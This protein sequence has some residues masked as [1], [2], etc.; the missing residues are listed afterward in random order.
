[1]L[2]LLTCHA[3]ARGT[4]VA[5]DPVC[6]GSAEAQVLVL[7]QKEPGQDCLPSPRLSGHLCAGR[8]MALPHLPHD[9]VGYGVTLGMPAP[10]WMPV[11]S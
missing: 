9:R 5:L 10:Y 6:P 3:A 11:S 7:A 2:S 1:M 8:L 4:G